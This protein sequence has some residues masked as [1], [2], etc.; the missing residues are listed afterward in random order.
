MIMHPRLRLRWLIGLAGFALL[1]VTPAGS[2]Q[3]AANVVRNPGAEESAAPSC[4]ANGGF[5]APA[6]WR[7]TSGRLTAL[8]N[9]C[10]PAVG[11][12]SGSQF[13]A[14]GDGGTS[15][16]FQDI[17][18]AADPAA[19]DGGGTR[20]TLSARLGGWRDQR[21]YATV[22]AAFLDAAGKTLGSLTVGPVTPA[23]RDNQTT[24]LPRSVTGSV[25]AKARR[26]RIVISASYLDGAVY[27]DGYVDDISLTLAPGP[28]VAP[29]PAPTSPELVPVPIGSVSNGCGGDM[30]K[31][32][33]K[34]M[35]AIGN[36]STFHNSNR[37]YNPTVRGFE[38][39][40][41]EACNLHDAGYAGAIVRD[42]LRGG[43]K[44]FR[45]WSRLQVDKKF[46][47]DLRL[48]CERQIPRAKSIALANCRASGGNLS[49]GAETRYN[50]VRCFGYKLFDADLG[51]P[52]LQTTG[53]RKNDRVSTLSRNCRFKDVRD[54]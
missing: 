40:F 24:L 46:L 52:G 16:A 31:F 14:G 27:N 19:I 2:S 53:P 39:D 49:F 34:I 21:D 33:L 54:A 26:A 48:L 6:G 20:A 17:D 42:K 29:P 11:G 5:A 28:P 9:D 18:L 22:R 32:L 12:V 8:K 41:T 3:S 51:R 47:A 36:T 23:D 43:I 4:L 10:Q 30:G 1:A 45:G 44:D 35:N 37:E 25:P 50:V 15:S 38:V 7:V 13:F